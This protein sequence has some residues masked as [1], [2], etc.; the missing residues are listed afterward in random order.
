M[1]TRDIRRYFEAIAPRYDGRVNTFVGERELR[2]IRAL[3][4]AGAAVFD[5][6]CGTGR[7]ALD[8]ARRGCR[9]TAYDSAAAMLRVAV[10]RASERVLD[11]EFVSDRA[12][13][14]GRTWPVVTCI[15]VLDY[16]RDATDLLRR[17]RGHL[18]LG[19]RMVVSVPNALSPLAW[20]YA[21]RGRLAALP[22]RPRTARALTRAASSA[23]LRVV[24]VRHA[25]PATAPLALTLVAALSEGAEA[26][27]TFTA[28][29]RS[30]SMHRP[31]E[32][33]SER[34]GS[35]RGCGSP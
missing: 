2:A 5:F 23:G 25:F 18:A 22:V 24:E 31:R 8:L 15:G 13:L 11:V 9:V 6:G 20:L 19:G 21:A 30:N 7:T 12:T 34:A 32:P 17:L 33:G 14:A 4:P 27:P 28:P 3:V 16:Y 29:E 10:K 26:V 1:S 35:E